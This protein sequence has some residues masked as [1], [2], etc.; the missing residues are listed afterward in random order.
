[1]ETV[2]PSKDDTERVNCLICCSGLRFCLY[3]QSKRADDNVP[4]LLRLHQDKRGSEE[5]KQD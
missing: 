4:I 3:F 2:A 1:M 5:E